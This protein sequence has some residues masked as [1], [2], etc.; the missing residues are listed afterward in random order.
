[1]TRAVE[2]LQVALDALERAE[3]LKRTENWDRSLAEALH[4]ATSAVEGV[5]LGAQDAEYEAHQ[6]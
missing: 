6:Q 4:K 2:Y 5:L 1:M 3:T